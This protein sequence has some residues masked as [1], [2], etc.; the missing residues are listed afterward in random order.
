MKKGKDKKKKEYYNKKEYYEKEDIEE[1][2]EDMDE[3]WLKKL[4]NKLLFIDIKFIYFF[5][6]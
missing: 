6:S 5:Y 2:E 1:D 4:R 3:L